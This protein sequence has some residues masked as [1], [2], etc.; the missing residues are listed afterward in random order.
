MTTQPT[1]CVVPAFHIR[2]AVPTRVRVGFAPG[3]ASTSQVL[4]GVDIQLHPTPHPY[5]LSLI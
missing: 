4:W 2:N 5:I 1:F 3:A